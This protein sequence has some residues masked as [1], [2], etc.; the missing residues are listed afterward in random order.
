MTMIKCE[1]SFSSL[2][3]SVKEEDPQYG[4]Q[5]ICARCVTIDLQHKTQKG[6]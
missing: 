4:M 2:D 1:T 6:T 3:R 5:N